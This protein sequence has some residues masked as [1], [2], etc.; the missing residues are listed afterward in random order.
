M[1][2]FIAPF[3][4]EVCEGRT[5]RTATVDRSFAGE[6]RLSLLRHLPNE[7]ATTVGDGL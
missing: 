2:T 3:P 1:L 6:R 5:S 4:G 7:S